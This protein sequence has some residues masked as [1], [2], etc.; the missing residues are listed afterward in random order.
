M[1]G[2][3]GD[4]EAF[5]QLTVGRFANGAARLNPR[6]R[7]GRTGQRGQRC[8]KEPK[9]VKAG[10]R[11]PC[12]A[13]GFNEWPH[14]KSHGRFGAPSGACAGSLP[15]LSRDGDGAAMGLTITVSPSRR[16]TTSSTTAF[17]I[18]AES[19]RPLLVRRH[20][21]ERD[22]HPPLDASHCSQSEERERARRQVVK[23]R[24]KLS[25][26]SLRTER[27]TMGNAKPQ[28]FRIAGA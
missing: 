18:R 3:I 17:V 1:T 5:A 4:G 14:W 13:D 6:N 7:P 21:G 11:L 20:V 19:M 12:F 25:P 27:L 15:D 24:R 26:S 10:L 23:R 28:V 2:S 16:D 22:Y 8:P 9:L